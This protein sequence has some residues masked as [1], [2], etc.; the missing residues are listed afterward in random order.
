M[1][2]SYIITSSL[3][4]NTAKCKAVTLAGYSQYPQFAI[5]LTTA[6]LLSSSHS[7]S[8][9][10]HDN[11]TAF[12]LTHSFIHSL[13]KRQRPKEEIATAALN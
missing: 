5:T 7:P 11:M 12:S 13:F 1:H 4:L 6:K 10:L 3:Q 9:T 2:T 8:A